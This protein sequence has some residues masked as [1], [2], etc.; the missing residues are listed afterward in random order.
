[1]IPVERLSLREIGLRQVSWIWMKILHMLPTL[2]E[3]LAL[4]ETRLVMLEKTRA[5]PLESRARFILQILIQRQS[6]AHR[7]SLATGV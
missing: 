1:M 7:M 2:R 6:P 5:A 4:A 3:N